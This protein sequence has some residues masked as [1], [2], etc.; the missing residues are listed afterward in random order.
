VLHLKIFCNYDLTELRNS[1]VSKL[2]LRLKL[3]NLFCFDV[4]VVFKVGH[5]ILNFEIVYLLSNV[6]SLVQPHEA[7]L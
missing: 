5:L 1:L 7:G 4:Q 6:D 3:L 2:K